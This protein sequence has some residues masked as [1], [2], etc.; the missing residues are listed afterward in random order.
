[1]VI[2]SFATLHVMHFARES[3]PQPIH[4]LVDAGWRDG[5]RDAHQ[6]ESDVFGLSLDRVAELPAAGNHE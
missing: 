1:M 2:R 4:E 6:V 3:G 5:R